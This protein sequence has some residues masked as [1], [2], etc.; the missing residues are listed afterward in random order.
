MGVAGDEPVYIIIHY[1]SFSAEKKGESIDESA[2]V[3][4]YIFF[5]FLFF[6]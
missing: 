5:S 6:L 1:H 2:A 3:R 4:Q